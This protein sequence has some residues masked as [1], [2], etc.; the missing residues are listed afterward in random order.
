MWATVQHDRSK[1]KDQ[2]GALSRAQ[3]MWLGPEPFAASLSLPGSI[4]QMCL[5]SAGLPGIWQLHA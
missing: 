4:S 2:H 1:T 5:A 3:A